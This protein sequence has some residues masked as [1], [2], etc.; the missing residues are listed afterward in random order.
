MRVTV[1]HS[2]PKA[3]AVQAVDRAVQDVF[4]TLAVPPLVIS[5]PQK[6]WNGSVMTFSLTAQMGFLKNAIAGTVEVTDRDIII[7]AD[8]GLLNRLLP[9][10]KV[11]TVLESRVRGFLT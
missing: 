7:D 6:N 2:K 3:E 10:E 11:R 4:Q 1:A 8:L 9:E 5:N